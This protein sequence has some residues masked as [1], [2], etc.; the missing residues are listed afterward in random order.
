MSPQSSVPVFQ[1]I[2][3]RD[4]VHRNIA[5]TTPEA[6]ISAVIAAPSEVCAPLVPPTDAGSVFIGVTQAL[7][8]RCFRDLWTRFQSRSAG[9]KANPMDLP[10]FIEGDPVS[11]DLPPLAD[12]AAFDFAY[13]LAAQPS[14]TPSIGACC[15]T[16]TLARQHPELMLRFQPGWRVLT[17]DWPVHRLLAETVTAEKLRALPAEPTRLRVAPV[18][19]GVALTELAPANH[20]L[21]LGLRSG[22]RLAEAARAATAFAADFDPYPVVAALVEA[23]AIVDAIL[24]PADSNASLP[25]PPLPNPEGRR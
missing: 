17:L 7:G 25:I 22:A 5:G 9:R 11:R 13:F 20:A 10:A 16:E 18:T 21:E 24:H 15:L 12:L 23:G 3:F 14:P 8:D 2:R 4:C 1:N 19:P 6:I